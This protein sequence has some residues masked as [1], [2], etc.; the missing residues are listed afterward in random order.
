MTIKRTKWEFV[1]V[2]ISSCIRRNVLDPCTMRRRRINGEGDQLK[3]YGNHYRL[4]SGIR[5]PNLFYYR[6]ET[7]SLISGDEFAMC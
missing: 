5:F 1:L 7:L 2:D 6:P 3:D 4:K